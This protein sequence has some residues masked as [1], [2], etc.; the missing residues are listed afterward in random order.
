MGNPRGTLKKLLIPTLLLLTPALCYGNTFTVPTNTQASIVATIATAHSAGSNN[1]VLLPAGTY[2]ITSQINVP[3]DNGLTITGPTAS[4]ATAILAASY[5]N[6]TIFALAG[7]SAVTIQYLQFENT[8]AVYMDSEANS[9]LTFVH[10]QISNLHG[11]AGIYLD[12]YLSTDASQATTVAGGVLQS[13]VSNTVIEYNT[14]GDAGSCTAEF[15][16]FDNYGECAGIVTHAGELLNLAIKYNYIFHV[17]EG[18]HLLQLSGFN[19]GA[20]SASC[21]SCTIDYNYILNY[22]RIGIENQVSAP[23]NP[24]YIE[25]NAVMEPINAFYGTFAMSMACCVTGFIQNGYSGYSPSLYYNDN[26]TISSGTEVGWGVHPPFAVEWWGTGAQGLNSL[27]EGNFSN[28]YVYGYGVAPWTIQNNYICGPH[29]ATEGGYIGNEEGLQPGPAQAGNIT[30]TSCT[31]MAVPAPAISQTSS[32]VT[33]TPQNASSGPNPGT[34]VSIYFTTDGS[35][36]TTSSSLYSAPFTPAIGSTVKAISVWGV[37]P[38]PTSFPSG[39]GWAPSTVVSAVFTG[40]APSN[41]AS[42]DPQG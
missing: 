36:P 20:T 5:S 24:I 23:I 42:P 25:H 27:I 10:N 32:A 35:T 40:S 9:G 28:G 31:T 39:Y 3:C 17:S 38:L 14:I 15:A 11:T 22:H 12:G 34:N 1:T 16:S 2:S 8:E 26:V 30:G 18:I 13:V 6:G 4:P 37:A 33:L 41:A 7:C 19:P 21:V 29:M